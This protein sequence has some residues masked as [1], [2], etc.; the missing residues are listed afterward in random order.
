MEGTLSVLVIF[1]DSELLII[2]I[3]AIDLQVQY[4]NM[5]IIRHFWTPW[6]PLYK[7]FKEMILFF[8]KIKNKFDL[9]VFSFV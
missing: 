8:K 1:Q 3:I 6:A 9:H 7:G 5:A 4:E 2:R